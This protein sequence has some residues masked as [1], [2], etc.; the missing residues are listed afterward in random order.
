MRYSLHANQKLPT[1]GKNY[2]SSFCHPPSLCFIILFD[3][4]FLQDFYFSFDCMYPSS[5]EVI[6]ISQ[7]HEK[8]NKID[9]NVYKVFEKG[10]HLRIS[11]KILLDFN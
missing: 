2:E 6:A 10:L 5:S 7:F 9:K 3:F 1:P 11:W 4:F 8:N